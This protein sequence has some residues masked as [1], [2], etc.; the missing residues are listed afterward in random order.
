MAGYFSEDFSVHANVAIG[1][2]DKDTGNLLEVRRSHNVATNTGKT[3]IAKLFGSSDYTQVPPTP[4]TTDKVA[5]IG[6]GV[7]GSLQSDN[8]YA[9]NQS[10][11]VTVVAL[12]DPTPYSQV[13][14]VKT[15]LKKIDNQVL[16]SVFF[17]GSYRTV[18][19]VDVLEKEISYTLAESLVSTVVM[20]T[21]VPISEAGLYLNTATTTWDGAAGVNPSLANQMVA[22]NTFDPLTVTPNV[23]LRV[24]WEFRVG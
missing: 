10:E 6:L 11:L 13:A 20:G 23:V 17:P 5:Y 9:N 21:S 22:Y 7:G 3:W 15:Y 1:M 18:F 14:G 12:E 19:I 16:N 24:E 2:Y 8:Q 4:H